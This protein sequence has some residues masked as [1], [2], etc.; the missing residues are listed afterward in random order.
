ML[1]SYANAHAWKLI[2]AAACLGSLAAC[3]SAPTQDKMAKTTT[4]TAPAD[5]QL[6]CANSTATTAKVEASKVLPIS[7]AKVDDQTYSVNLDAA[8]KKFTCLVD[9][10]GSVKSVTPMATVQ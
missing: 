4:D 7:S 10:N 2:L 1:K 9:M 5:L 3:Q 6:L 8:G